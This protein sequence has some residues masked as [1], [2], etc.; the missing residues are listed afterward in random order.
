LTERKI[1]NFR[2]NGASFTHVTFMLIVIVSFV[3]LA[4]NYGSRGTFGLFVKPLASQF[5]ASRGAISL[6]LVFNML[7][8][9]SVAILTGHLNDKF[10]S[11]TVLLFG[12]S[13]SA[14][15]LLISGA[16]LSLLQIT[17]SFGILFGAA[18]CLLSQITVVSLLMKL[19]N[20]KMNSL[21]IGLVGSGPGIGN[22][23]L[24]P[25][26]AVTLTRTDWSNAMTVIG[27]LFLIYIL[28]PLLLLP[29][30][31]QQPKI[32]KNPLDLDRPKRVLTDINIILMFYSFFF[33]RRDLWCPVA[34]GRLCNR[35]RLIRK[36]RCMGRRSC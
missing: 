20:R 28:F 4:L 19:L 21:V 35:H 5:G 15:S 25:A 16:A 31:D 12:G 29:R 1:L 10:G 3:T 2:P 6:I 14:T 9:G 32:D 33:M 11:R 23:I 13:L 26:I 22:I 36:S 17:F 24:L 18:T 27:C 7:V 8:Y 34:G 30:I